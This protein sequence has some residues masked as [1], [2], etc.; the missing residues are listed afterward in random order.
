MASVAD[1]LPGAQAASKRPV[2]WVAIAWFLALLIL[3]YFPILKHLVEQWSYDE[4]VLSLI[5]I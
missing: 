4:D 2:P 1:Q 3:T 5:H